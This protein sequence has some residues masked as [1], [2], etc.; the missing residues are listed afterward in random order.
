MLVRQLRAT[1]V[2]LN[3]LHV[4]IMVSVTAAG[5]KQEHNLWT[6][7]STVIFTLLIN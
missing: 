6:A 4:C 5:W 1:Q 3:L 2:N 7:R